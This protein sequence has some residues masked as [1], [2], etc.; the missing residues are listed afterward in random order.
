MVLPE[1]YSLTTEAQSPE[2]QL[3]APSPKFLQFMRFAFAV[4]ICL[5]ALATAIM[6]ILAVN[7]FRTHKPVITPSWGSL[8]FLI[9]MGFLT[10]IIYFGYYIF[11]PPLPFIRRGSFL[12]SLFMMKID[13]LFQFGMC[14]IWI[15]GALAYASDFRGREN[16]M[17]DGY[18]HYPKPSDWNHAC[19]LLNWTVP[20]A[21]A[22]FGLE[23]GLL[24]FE[25]LFTS[26]I[27]LF[28]D[29]E[30]LNEVNYEWGRRAYEFQHQP[31]SALSSFNNPMQYRAQS[32]N[33]SGGK[34]GGA[35]LFGKEEPDMYEQYNEKR[36]YDED[37]GR[38]GYKSGG[39]FANGT[40]DGM[41]E[42]SSEYSSSGQRSRR[43]AAYN[44]PSSYSGSE[45][46]TM[47]SLSNYHGGAYSRQSV[48]SRRAGLAEAPMPAGAGGTSAL[49]APSWTAPSITSDGD[50]MRDSISPP[51]SRTGV[52]GQNRRVSAPV[53]LGSRGR[54]GAAYA[55]SEDGFDDPD[56][57]RTAVPSEG[58]TRSASTRGAR[59]VG[60]R[61]KQM[62]RRRMSA[63]EESGWH[64]REV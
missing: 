38:T 41:S 7:Y 63:D 30:V 39:G 50:T 36:Y 12:S 6:A 2:R 60:P 33:I 25:L 27:F 1:R 8:I 40:P 56:E 53:S 10:S 43:G 47:A 52:A 4:L 57:Y 29:Q 19:D 18:Y 21:Y 11:L 9:V 42:Y 26:Y 59:P 64:L 34:S 58:V 45:T 54:R 51:E 17:F 13:L 49:R 20:L 44:D 48:N 31:P 5:M 3:P 14:S 35:R 22:T 46:S 16:C 55:A 32:R 15:S 28:I 37:A 62:P 61:T 24:G 23:A